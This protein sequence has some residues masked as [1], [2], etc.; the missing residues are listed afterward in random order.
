[1]LMGRTRSN[2][3]AICIAGLVACSDDGG[4]KDPE[5]DGSVNPGGGD[6]GPNSNMDSGLDGS[7]IGRDATALPDGRTIDPTPDG[8][9]QVDT[10]SGTDSGIDAGSTLPCGGSCNDNVDCTIDSCVNNKCEHRVDNDSCAAGSSCNLT[11]GCQQGGACTTNA[12][13]ADTNGC[14]SNERCNTQLARCEYDVLDRD[15]DGYPP[16]ACAG[17][18]CDDDRGVVNPSQTES[19]NGRDDDCDG[20]IDDG[21]TVAA[22]SACTDGDVVCAQGYED[23][24]AGAAVL[25]ANTQTDPNNCGGCGLEFSCGS[26]G[27]CIAG[28]CDC[29]P[30]ANVMECTGPNAGCADLSKSELNCGTCGNGCAGGQGGVFEACIASSCVAC[31]GENEPCCDNAGLALISGCAPGLT[32]E[33][34]AGAVGSKCTCAAGSSKCGDACVDLANDEQNCGECGMACGAN[35]VCTADGCQ[36]CGGLGELCCTPFGLPFCTGGRVCGPDDTC[37][38]NNAGGGGGPGNGNGPPG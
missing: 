36:G 26:G 32:C 29:P 2:V 15:G 11:M 21:V 18:D 13:C 23:C 5:S 37:V 19:C 3:L 4:K 1:M 30:S 34:G 9:E 22:G 12:D 33:G 17:T 27:V 14:T 28:V 25:C 38:I 8:G 24:A 10:D 20:A 7:L 16:A 31:G 35:E 6:G